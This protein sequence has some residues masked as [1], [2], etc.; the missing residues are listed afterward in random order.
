MRGGET[1]CSNPNSAV[2]SDVWTWGQSKYYFILILLSL[3]L[4]ETELF[5]VAIYYFLCEKDCFLLSY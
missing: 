1:V 2:L 4:N 5:S 3:I